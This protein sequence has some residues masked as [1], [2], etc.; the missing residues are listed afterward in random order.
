M[1]TDKSETPSARYAPLAVWIITVATLVFIAFKVI[2]YGYIPAGDARRHVAKA[3]TDRTYSEIIVLTP[4]YGTDQSPGWDWILHQ[5]HVATGWDRDKL[6]SFSVV[7][8]LLCVFG[9][10]LPFVRRPEAWLLAL[11]AQMVAIPE[12]MTR[13]TQARP[14]L[15]TEAVLIAILFAWSKAGERISGWKIIFTTIGV[16]LSVCIHGTWYLW[17]LPLAAFFLA[18]AWR[19]LVG[20]TCCVM[21]GVL[22]G[23]LMTGKPFVFLKASVSM[24]TLV[25][26][27]HVPQWML[28][29]EFQPSYG[30]FAT[31]I[32]VAV[33]YLW[34][35]Q[36]IAAEP[37]WF[38]QPV[39]WMFVI[40]WILGFKA[41]RF[42]ADWGLPAAVVWLTLQFEEI[43]QRRHR[44]HSGLHHASHGALVRFLRNV[45]ASIGGWLIGI[46]FVF[47]FVNIGMSIWGK[48][49]ISAPDNPWD[50][51]TLEWF[52]SSPPSHHNFER[53]PPIR[54]ERPVWDFNH[55][56]YVAID[57]LAE[58]H[59]HQLAAGVGSSTGSPKD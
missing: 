9:A 53:L 1:S 5:L 34:R 6:I 57:H 44:P 48:N 23:G 16:A 17:A 12:L 18:G 58:K 3:F 19:R 8:L 46:S 54:S 47:M 29:G 37:K 50:A 22:L 41:D 40:C 49:A 55:P 33:V 10:A 32:L 43:L 25:F 31:V 21:A 27:E 38:R 56:D 4:E 2:T 52:T 11:L 39:V 13:W 35:R 20:L 42:W 28:V 24:V 15:L 45:A 51:G 59:A 30:E 14:F 26:K 36:R 7:S